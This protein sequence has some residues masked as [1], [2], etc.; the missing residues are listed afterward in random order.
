MVKLLKKMGY[1]RSSGRVDWDELRFDFIVL[2][3]L[4]GLFYVLWGTL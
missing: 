1:I 4:G 2:I 3:L